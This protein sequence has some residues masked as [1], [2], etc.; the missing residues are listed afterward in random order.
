LYIQIFSNRF[1]TH[2]LN[3]KIKTMKYVI[4]GSL[5]HTSKPILTA[6]IKAGHEA[7]SITSNANRVKEIEALGAK[8]AVGSLENLA[9]VKETFSG[10]DAVY[11]MVP[12]NFG[13][14]DWK[15][16]IG[17]VGKNYSE[18]IKANNIKHVVNLS[19]VGAHMADGCG[20]VS[21][22]H[23]V[24]NALN[25][26]KA[27]NIKHL[28]PS[29]FY[30]N[31]LT[32]IGL[33]KAMGIMGSNFAV[34]N[35]RLGLVATD[36]IAAIAIESLLSLNFTGQTIEYIA[37]DDVNTDDIAVAIGNAIGKPGLQWVQFSDEQALAGMLQ[38][39]LSEEIAKNYVEMGQAVH[40][41]KMYEDYWMNHPVIPAAPKLADFAKT[42]AA[43]YQAG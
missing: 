16:Y 27:V 28:R 7:T 34:T 21:G 31:L 17:Q 12:P 4:T 22:L 38:A 5:G 14:T 26:L 41:G 36:H 13:A 1:Y 29:Y 30:N 35:N 10:A 25:D 33:I 6:L 11:T 23:R 24:E 20:P 15:G 8:A 9:F 42:F 18:A 37:N 39:G 19:S 32:N 43:A 3:N 2:Y 40:S